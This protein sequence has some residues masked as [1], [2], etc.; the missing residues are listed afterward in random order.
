MADSFPSARYGQRGDPHR[1]TDRTLF[2]TTPHGIIL[3][4]EPRHAEAVAARL[5]RFVPA[6]AFGHVTSGDYYLVT[7][8]Y[9]ET[10]RL[11]VLVTTGALLRLS[12]PSYPHALARLARYG[13][14]AAASAVAA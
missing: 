5:A 11:L 6:Y 2:V 4:V 10:T 7:A 13:R 14:G 12:S 3:T 8:K 9:A 1:L